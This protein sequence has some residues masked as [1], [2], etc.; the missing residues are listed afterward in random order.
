MLEALLKCQVSKF[1][2]P[3]DGDPHNVIKNNLPLV[4]N[5]DGELNEGGKK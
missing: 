4:T 5:A 2:Q 1:D 3:D